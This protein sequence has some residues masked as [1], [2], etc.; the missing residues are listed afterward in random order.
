MT[1][2]SF[3][4]ATGPHRAEP[5]RVT[6]EN[7]GLA[8]YRVIQY[9]AIRQCPR[10]CH[11]ASTLQRV[12]DLGFCAYGDTHRIHGWTKANR[13]QS[14]AQ[15][16]IVRAVS[17][18]CELQVEHLAGGVDIKHHDHGAL[19]LRRHWDW[20]QKQLG[21]RRWIN[22]AWPAA[23]ARPNTRTLARANSGAN[24]TSTARPCACAPV[25]PCTAAGSSHRRLDVCRNIRRRRLWL[26]RRFLLWWRNNGRWHN[27][28]HF[29]WFD[30]RWQNR[31]H[32]GGRDLYELN[33]LVFWNTSSATISATTTTS[34]TSTTC[35]QYFV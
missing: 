22:G 35:A 31:R 5:E 23:G 30:Q 28:L 7:R 33:A 21:R 29:G 9:A 32:E 10:Q 3:G 14:F 27:G 11:F 20:W 25:R 6:T 18:R 2:F 24:A 1:R 34:R 17:R 15:F 13:R 19:R 16:A 12:R 4:Q 26:F 8:G